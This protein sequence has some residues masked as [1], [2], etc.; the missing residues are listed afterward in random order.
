MEVDA[1]DIV[2]LILQ[3][4]KENS[5]PS[6]MRALQE[7]SQ[8]ELNTVDSI[9]D[10]VSNVQC[11]HWDNVLA[12][13][14]TL[15]L[16]GG[17]LADIY[18]Q[19]VLE[20]IEL[21]ELDTARQLLQGPLA[22]LKEWHPRQYQKLETLAGR[23]SF[24]PRE[25]YSGGVTKERQRKRLAESLRAGVSSAPPSRLL[26]LL[27]QALKWQQHQGELPKGTRFD[28]YTGSAA[29]RLVE[30]EDFVSAAGPVRPPTAEVLGAG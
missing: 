19:V 1:A 5:L 27:G 14:N 30:A 3:F 7:E 4:L 23:S 13:V 25:A 6:A 16:P 15:A 20:M 2:K 22:N 10:L 12:L 28:I 29:T 11:G 24:D 17:I 21:R 9:D 26:A 18:E 8:V